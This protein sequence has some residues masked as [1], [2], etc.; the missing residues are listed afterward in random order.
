[1]AARPGRRI[2][3]GRA[4]KL[5]LSL[6]TEKR[7]PMRRYKKEVNTVGENQGGVTR[8]ELGGGKRAQGKR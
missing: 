3:K 7:T 2:E 6:T 1:V 5:V 8:L 4:T